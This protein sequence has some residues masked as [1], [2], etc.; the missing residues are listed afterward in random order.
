MDTEY[1]PNEEYMNL[2]EEKLDMTPVEV[3]EFLFSDAYKNILDTIEKKIG[4][5]SEQVTTAR[6][7]LFDF[8]IHFSTKEEFENTID[9]LGL[10]EENKD[11][12]LGYIQEFIIDPTISEITNSLEEEKDEIGVNNIE[13]VSSPENQEMGQLF[14]SIQA[15][16]Q[17]PS[18]VAPIASVAQKFIPGS[19]NKPMQNPGAPTKSTDPYRE[20]PL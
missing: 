1:N 10:S 12:F 13:T 11:I 15:K 20:M 3:R 17:K 2:Y 4:F 8:L 6:N 5:T 19:Q 18:V 7:A 9:S 14:A 16:M